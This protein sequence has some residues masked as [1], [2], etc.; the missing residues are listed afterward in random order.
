MSLLIDEHEI[1]TWKCDISLES[2]KKK[3]SESYPRKRLIT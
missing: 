2:T 3:I 1:V